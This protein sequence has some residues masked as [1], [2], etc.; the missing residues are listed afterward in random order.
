MNKAQ[1]IEF[2]AGETGMTKVDA[3]KSLEAFMKGVKETLVSGDR[4]QLTGFGTFLCGCKS[5]T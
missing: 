2:M 1:L 4:I 3:Q 5:S